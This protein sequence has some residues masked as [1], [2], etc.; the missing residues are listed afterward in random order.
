MSWLNV[1]AADA[2][3]ARPI[4][5]LREF[6]G[7]GSG[8]LLDVGCGQGT[9]SDSLVQQGYRV[10]GI[11]PYVGFGMPA[12]RVCGN[13]HALPM[14]NNVFDKVLL[15]WSLHHV[16]DDL[17]GQAIREAC[18]V[19]VSQGILY[20]VEPEPV[21]SSQVVSRPFHDETKV[22]ALAAAAVDQL[23]LEKGA[24]RR[25]AYYV[26]E[27]RYPNF[28]FFVD[29]MMSRAYNRYQVE[30][31]CQDVVRDA[32]EACREEGEYRL[33]HRIRMEEIRW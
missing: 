29:D 23:V 19:L 20:V 4:D 17:M 8:T 22:Q 15:H 31:L 30:D 12:L 33:R 5:A 13:A 3:V 16:P 26:S 24:H 28:D 14:A 25:R 7:A 21:G 11:D 1:D 9:L 18:R 2:V 10:T 6:L 32:F 27:D